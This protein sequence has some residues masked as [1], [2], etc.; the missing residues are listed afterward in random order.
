M[1]KGFDWAARQAAAYV[2]EDKPVGPCYA[3]SLPGRNAFCVRDASHQALGAHVLGADACNRNIFRRFA[4]AISESKGFCS[5]WEITFDGTPC[6]ADYKDDEDFWYNLPANFDLMDACWRMFNWTADL[7]YLQDTCMEYFHQVSVTDYVRH[8]DR[9]NDG[10][11]DRRHSDGRRGIAGYDESPRNSGYLTAADLLGAEYAA[12]YARGKMLALKGERKNSERMA[13]RSAELRR[14]YEEAWWNGAEGRFCE[15]GYANGFGGE[16]TGV[17]AFL[18]LYY[19]MVSDYDKL[20]KQLAY[21]IK[22]DALHNEEERSY[23]PEI[24]WRYGA[25]EAAQRI[26]LAMTSPGYNRREYPEVS[27]AALGA[28]AAGYMGVCPDAAE[29]ALVTRSAVPD[30]GFAEI[31]YLPLWGGVIHLRH[32]SKQASVLENLTGRALKWTARFDSGVSKT[33]DVP[34]GHTARLRKD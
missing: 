6:P 5:W 11:P 3:A 33:L 4:E 2:E 28:V 26:W 20:N 31:N 1:T 13:A 32:E 19:N 16:Y 17:N 22:N 21:V 30:G 14:I 23:M 24:L 10:I 29:S 27:F 9:D 7:G 25:D 8:W 34:A 15:V 12:F 18:P